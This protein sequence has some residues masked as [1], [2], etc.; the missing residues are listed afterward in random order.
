M[1]T[2][3][4][5]CWP[6]LREAVESVLLQSEC[7][8]LLVADGG[9]SDGSLDLLRELAAVD[10]RLHLV[11]RSDHGPADALNKA[12]QA[13]RGTLIGWLNADDIY[14]PGALARAKAALTAHPH[15]LMVYGEGEEFDLATG[16]PPKDPEINAAHKQQLSADQRRRNEVEGVRRRLDRRD[17]ATT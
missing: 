3:C 13:A 15:W 6:F 4:I 14:S 17:C 8:E 2:R 5:S 10:S 9:S 7:L 11:S 1:A 12:F 16:R